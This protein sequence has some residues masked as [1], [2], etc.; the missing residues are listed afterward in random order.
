MVNDP[1]SNIFSLGYGPTLVEDAEEL[2]RVIRERLRTTQSHE[3]SY[4]DRR[5][6]ELSFEVD[7]HVYLKVTRMKGMHR[8]K[9]KGK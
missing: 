3:K 5:H 2:V 1:N 9:V 7:Y 6:R 4:V 8:F